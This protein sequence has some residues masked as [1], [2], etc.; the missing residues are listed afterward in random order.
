M[1]YTAIDNSQSVIQ[2]YGKKGM[3]WGVR[4]RHKELKDL[5]RQH[6]A[7]KSN[8]SNSVKMYGK[9]MSPAYKQYLRNTVKASKES[10]KLFE[11]EA[12]KKESKNPKRAAKWDK[13]MK[14]HQKKYDEILKKSSGYMT[15]VGG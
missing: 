11:Y 15:R 8:V 14:K 10:N 1:S 12:L 9:L 4:R 2:H 3:K 7:I 5:S 6:R 13:K